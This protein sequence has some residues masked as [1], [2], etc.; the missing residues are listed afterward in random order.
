MLASAPSWLLDLLDPPK[1]IAVSASDP[2][3]PFRWL[4]AGSCSALIHHNTNKAQREIDRSVLLEDEIDAASADYLEV[5]GDTGART[6][7][8][9]LTFL[10]SS[11][12]CWRDLWPT[13]SR[14]T[15]AEPGTFADGFS[16]AG[17]KED[18]LSR[19]APGRTRFSSHRRLRR[20]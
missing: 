9:P 1:V 11:A 4:Q 12:A 16:A 2:V 19:R 13:E 8:R 14:R 17:P 7:G 15:L 3:R 6:L 10:P 20:T 18:F 5:H